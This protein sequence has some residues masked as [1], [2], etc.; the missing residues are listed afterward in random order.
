MECPEKD[1]CSSSGKRSVLK[2]TVVLRVRRSDMKRTVVVVV[3][4]VL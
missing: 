4:G 3:R 1:V 2:R